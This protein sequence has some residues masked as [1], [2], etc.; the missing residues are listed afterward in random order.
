MAA[1]ITAYLVALIVG[2]TLIAGLIVCAQRD[3]EGPVDLIVLNGRVYTADGEGTMA[4]A[5]AVQGN[6]ILRVGTT[7]E[8]QR[9][10]RAQTIVVDAK[11]GAVVPGFN[12]AHVQLLAG[13]LALAQI[14]LL[15]ARTL[16][17]IQ[18]T[19]RS[20]ATAHPE[21][22]WVT[23]RGWHDEPFAGGVPTRQM[24]D[25]LVPDRPAYLTSYDGHTGWMNSLALTRAGITRRTR[26]PANGV[27]VKDPRSGEPTGVVKEAAMGLVT[28]LL[29]APTPAEQRTA[30]RAAIAE[31]HRRG[32]T[33][34]QNAGGN[35]AEL[36]LY[37]ELRR[38]GALTVRV[39][40]A[41]SAGRELSAAEL[42][43][44]EQLRIKYSDDPLFKTGAVTIVT[45]GQVE[46][47]TAAL[48]APYADRPATAGQPAITAQALNRVVAEL[49]KRGWQVMLH[50]AGDRAIRMGLDAFE[51]AAAN[52]P[53]PARGRRHRL[54][55]IETID[56]ADV[57]R[58]ATLGVIAS[59]QPSHGLLD[60]G[61][62]ALWNTNLGPERAA[63]GPASG[64]IVRGG[65]RIAF[66]SN[67]PFAPMNP[68]RGLH[69]AVNRTTPEGEPE[70]GWNAAERLTL[71]Q[72]IDAYTRDAA[73]ASFD[74][75]RKGS[76]VRDM[77]ADL[78]ILSR[79][80]FA[81]PA[82]RLT[83]ADVQ[84]TILDGK[85]VYRRAVETDN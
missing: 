54:E 75:H 5:V 78:V 37:D 31:A 38:D 50:A 10:R 25:E 39:Y 77:L 24:L 82:S 74:E 41:L 8:I 28:G 76:L 9:L 47:H 71:T 14:D 48:L 52:N 59:M 80:V 58:L 42:D 23:G 81:L 72:A 36:A 6:K 51:Q 11:G 30:V 12:D 53:L 20:W 40:H 16:P 66:G 60:A 44:F 26:N 64:S 17:D 68:L 35:A 1:R 46:S 57:P 55:Q 29:P 32:V 45:D 18:D 27:I 43:A 49:D 84:M 83:D 21:R 13:G 62:I 19:I 3:D 2:T 69:V 63:R 34:V 22:A 85:V 4:E 73:W 7:R 15:E 56:P 33:S 79:D 67:W 61:Q 65:A 70:G